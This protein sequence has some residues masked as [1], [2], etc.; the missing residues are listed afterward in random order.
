MKIF[1]VVLFFILS[2]HSLSKADNIRD[3]EIER[4]SIGDSLLDY[5]SEDEI[6]GRE[7]DL[8]GITDKHI[9]EL[10]SQQEKKEQEIME[11]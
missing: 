9:S 8:Q 11:V 7:T 3:F 10:N 2:L 5:I 4:M 1:I 6:K